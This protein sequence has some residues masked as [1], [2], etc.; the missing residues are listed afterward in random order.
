MPLHLCKRKICIGGN[1]F[2][3]SKKKLKPTVRTL[4]GLSCCRPG[5]SDGQSDSAVSAATSPVPTAFYVV[6][7]SFFC[8]PSQLL[9]TLSKSVSSYQWQSPRNCFWSKL[10]RNKSLEIFQLVSSTF[11]YWVPAAYQAHPAKSWDTEII[12][13]QLYFLKSPN[14]LFH[15]PHT[16]TA[17]AALVTKL[18][19]EDKMI[20]FGVIPI[21]L[22]GDCFHF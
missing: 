17:F 16:L 11:T 1:T 6:L 13:Y 14:Q 10:A 21:T 3:Y 5:Y 4:L 2:F 12:R 22:H 20:Y 18:F 7:F 15:S 19:T 8:I 9:L